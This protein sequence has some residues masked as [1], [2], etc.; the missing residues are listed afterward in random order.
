[1]EREADFLYIPALR[2]QETG[3]FQ[4]PSRERWQCLRG[5]SSPTLCLAGMLPF[6]L[7][8]DRAL[9]QDQGCRKWGAGLV[10]LCHPGPEA[11][12]TA[13]LDK[14][15]DSEVKNKSAAGATAECAVAAW[16]E[17]GMPLNPQ[18]RT[19]RNKTEQ[20][21]EVDSSVNRGPH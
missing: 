17:G 16:P 13:S 3:M 12:V 10:L 5:V 21:R 20:Q 8:S 19:T 11:D 1:M 2:N 4:W 18:S 15:T 14:E 9:R 7:V 6:L